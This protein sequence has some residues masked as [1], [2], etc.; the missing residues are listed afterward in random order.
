MISSSRWTVNKNAFWLRIFH[1]FCLYLLYN[2][3]KSR[4]SFWYTNIIGSY[5][6]SINATFSGGAHG[7]PPAALFS[8]PVRRDELYPRRP[9]AVFVA[10]GTAAVHHRAG[11]RAVRPAVRQRPPQAGGGAVPADAGRPPCG[12]PVC[13]ARPHRHQRVPRAG[14][15][16]RA[17]NAAG[18]IPPAVPPHC[19]AVP[20][21]G[22]RCR[23]RWRG[24]GR[25][26][27]R[28]RDGP[29]LRRQGAGP[30]HPP[31]RPRLPAGAPGAPVLGE[32]ER[33]SRRAA[34]PA[35]AAA[36]PAAGSVCPP[37]GQLRPGRLCAGRGGGPQLLSGLPA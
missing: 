36:Q 34:G 7:Y 1:L 33:S 14:L 6:R 9:A 3:R 17:G 5:S 23:G 12:D 10:P 27:R 4:Y 28:S 11:S 19:N 15:P 37:V 25:A 29:G 32:R 35:R 20:P 30:H 13:P 2:S 18:Q 16:A 8:G 22:Q 24:A 26:G 21:F 31:G